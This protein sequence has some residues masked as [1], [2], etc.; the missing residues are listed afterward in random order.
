MADKTRV[1][2]RARQLSRDFSQA[3]RRVRGSVLLD[4]DENEDV[5]FSLLLWP[6]L[7]IGVPILVMILK[8]GWTQSFTHGD[9]FFLVLG[10]ALGGLVES[11][12]DLTDENLRRSLS[13]VVM[14][15]TYGLYAM[16]LLAA[17]AYSIYVIAISPRPAK[18]PVVSGFA[19]WVFGVGLTVAFG[20]RFSLRTRVPRLVQSKEEA[21]LA[22]AVGVQ[23]GILAWLDRRS[24]ELF[25]EL[26][27]ERTPSSSS[28]ER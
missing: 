20:F 8:R 14:R 2:L 21:E 26:V 19:V 17:L 13:T 16:V 15:V 23:A 10:V 12:I 3:W 6:Y 1:A 4:E 25:R 27:A 24:P 22:V 7:V 5:N 11:A 9:A 18:N 28:T